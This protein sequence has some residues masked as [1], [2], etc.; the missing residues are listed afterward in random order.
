M[1][2]FQDAESRN[3]GLIVSRDPVNVAYGHSDLGSRPT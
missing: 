1:N 3:L 2:V